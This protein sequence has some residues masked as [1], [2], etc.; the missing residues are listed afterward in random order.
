MK[1]KILLITLAICV[2][3]AGCASD[4]PK[5]AVEIVTSHSRYDEETQKVERGTFSESFTVS[6]GDIFYEDF[7]G[8][9]I[10]NP[11]DNSKYSGIIAEITAVDDDD[12]TVIIYGEETVI[13][14][15]TGRKI[16]SDMIIYDGPSYNYVLNVT[17]CID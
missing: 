6:A 10:L 12:A 4:K 15:G 13:R 17:R 7:D 3:F 16:S 11:D 5:C 1:I 9:W 2:I 14:Y 8:K